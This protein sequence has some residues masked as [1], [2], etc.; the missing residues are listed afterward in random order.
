MRKVLILCAVLLI[1]IIA[2]AGKYFSVLAGKDNNVIKALNFIPADAALVL[3]FNNN[4]SFYEIFKDYKLFDAVL[5]NQRKAEISQIRQVISLPALKDY[6]LDKN[7]FV[8]FHPGKD[9]IE[10]LFT[11]NL[12]DQYSKQ[13]LQEAFME[14]PGVSIVDNE[15]GIYK[16]DTNTPSRPFYIYLEKGAAAG[17]F[18]SSLLQKCLTNGSPRLAGTFVSEINKG[19]NKNQ[20][21]PINLF[22]NHQS[23]S[24]FLMQFLSGSPS[25]NLALLK[26]IKGTSSLSL[27]F[28]SDAIMFN[29]I[30]STDTVKPE[31]INIFLH[32]KA[33][34]N[35]LKKVL[36][37][38]TANFL[39]FAL[40]DMAIYHEDLSRYFKQTG[41][42]EKLKAQLSHVKNKSGIDLD[43]DLK[44]QW[45]K[46][47]VSVENY[48]GE[49][50]VIIKLKNGSK[51]NFTLQLISRQINEQ[52]SQVNYSDI[53]YYYFGE[54]L[55]PY[56][57]PYFAVTDNYLILANTPG[58][59]SNYLSEYQ[60]DRFLINTE[61]FKQ[62]DQL[63]ANQSNILYFVHTKNSKRKISSSLK[64]RYSAAFSDNN[65]GLNNFYG[66]S[67]QWTSDEDHFFTNLYLS[68]TSP[69]SLIAKSEEE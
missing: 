66:L 2:I 45:E 35:N 4:D 23:V 18:S 29:G 47:F 67:Y 22:V 63:V 27:N 16:Y 53:F 33:G 34:P 25:T 56:S 24:P 57:K 21:S 44:P 64:R 58:I 38:N 46:E 36:P 43:R 17:S 14:L 6:T 30:S 26:N 52:I 54:P 65:F 15:R 40:S 11:M 12:E 50:F 19:S 1:A 51:V 48:F 8:S 3:H 39:A 69:D 55:K 49:K 31:Y 68:Y 62:Y 41:K 13:A 59:I 28:K 5:G 60:N 7:I 32:Q 9:S 10:F 61:S 20:S 37:Q 42:L